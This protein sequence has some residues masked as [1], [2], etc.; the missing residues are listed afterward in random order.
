M[1]KKKA[2]ADPTAVSKGRPKA[3]KAVA[4]AGSAFVYQLKI[5]LNGIKPPIWRR[6]QTQDCTLDQLHRIIQTSLGWSDSHLHVFEIGGEQY[7]APEQWDEG[8]SRSAAAA[9]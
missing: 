7:G 1:P 6:V 3:V 2:D 4:Q 9:R 8:D 5:T